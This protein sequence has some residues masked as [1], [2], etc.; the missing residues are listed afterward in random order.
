MVQNSKDIKMYIIKSLPLPPLSHPCLPS[1][2][3]YKS[4]GILH[5]V[6]RDLWIQD[7]RSSLNV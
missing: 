7:I 2:F 3:F 5:N 6:D 1:F 4:D